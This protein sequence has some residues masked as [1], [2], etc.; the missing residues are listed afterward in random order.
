MKRIALALC[1]TLFLAGCAVNRAPTTQPVTYTPAQTLILG[2][3]TLTVTLNGIAN[4]RDLGLITQAEVNSYKPA[5]DA[6][7]AVRNQAEKD[8]RAGNVT[9][10]E[11][12]LK[13]YQ[14][15]LNQ[16]GPLL[17]EI[18]AKKAS[19]TQPH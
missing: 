15:G 19:A 6:L 12:Y 2:T 1:L 14:A 17:A 4:A 10:A 9:D 5:V 8:L 3:D 13:Q 18:A 7:I 11:S 16:L